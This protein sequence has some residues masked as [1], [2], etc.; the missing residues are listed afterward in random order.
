MLQQAFWLAKKEFKSQS[1]SIIS[2]VG[3]T[4]LIAIF[5]SILLEQSV[6]YLFGGGQIFDRIAIMDIIFLVLTPSFGAIFMSRPYLSFQTI[7][8]DPFSKRMALF[9]SLPIPVSVLSLSRMLLMFVILF[10]M[11]LAFYVTITVAL[12]SHFFEYMSMS[13]YLIFILFWFG[14]SLAIAGINPFIEFGTNGKVLHIVPWIFIFVFIVMFILTY[15][16][17]ERGIVETVLILVKNHGWP[18]ALVSIIVGLCATFIWNKLLTIRLQRR[19][20]L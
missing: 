3:A 15:N 10:I 4:I 16:L 9:R 1:V 8:D 12:P 11:S 20:Y 6:S 17:L 14:Y 5:T 18:L 13:E 7:K 19:D 2:T